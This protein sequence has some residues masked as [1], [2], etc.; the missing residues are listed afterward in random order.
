MSFHERKH[1]IRLEDVVVLLCDKALTGPLN[2]YD[3][4]ILRYIKKELERRKEMTMAKQLDSPLS[5]HTV[6][7]RLQSLLAQEG[8][9]V[10]VL[11]AVY[12]ANEKLMSMGKAVE[13]VALEPGRSEIV[14]RVQLER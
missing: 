13:I 7:R 2:E 11:F 10:E 12:D 6:V 14:I 4:R 3:A 5:L 1:P 8:E 9:N